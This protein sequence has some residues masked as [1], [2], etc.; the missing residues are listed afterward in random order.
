[1]SNSWWIVSLNS[2][3]HLCVALW[4]H[5]LFRPELSINSPNICSVCKINTYGWNQKIPSGLL[6]MCLERGSL[7]TGKVHAAFRKCR[8][9]LD[10]IVFLLRIDASKDF[11]NFI[12]RRD[13]TLYMFSA[14]MNP[15]G[16]IVSKSTGVT[17]LCNLSWD[18]FYCIPSGTYSS[19]ITQRFWLSIFEVDKEK[20]LYHYTFRVWESRVLRILQ[21]GTKEMKPPQ[22]CVINDRKDQGRSGWV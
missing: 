15:A 22:L 3:G 5:C 1:M 17:C 19:I 12:E 11:P 18:A 14:V 16:M 9:F 13:S 20:T 2:F 7:C 6:A 21:R 4:S 8:D 10:Q